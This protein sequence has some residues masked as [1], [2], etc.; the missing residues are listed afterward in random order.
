MSGEDWA[1]DTVGERID[2]LVRFGFNRADIEAFLNEHE[3]GQRERL[4]W[5]EERREAASALEDRI[6]AFS[7]HSVLGFEA[8]EPYKSRLSDPFTIEETFLE[9]ERELRSLAPWEPPLNREKDAWFGEGH[10]DM[11]S[12]LYE[13]LAALDVSSHAAVAPLHRLFDSPL[14]IDELLR[15]LELVEADERRQRQMIQSGADHLRGLGYA[16]GETVEQPLLEA[17]NQL[18]L[19]QG[20][21]A[22]KELVRLNA[23]QMIQPFDEALAAEFELR[24]SQLLDKENQQ[25]LDELSSEV[26]EVAQTLE[27][28]RQVFSDRI[29]EWRQQGIVF[30]HEGD[31][32]PSDL[33]EWEANHDTIAASV[34]RHLELVGRWERFARYWPSRVEGSR[35]L[36]GH[37]EMTDGLQDVVDELDALWKQLELDGLELLQSYEHAGLAV[38]AWQQ[39]VFDDPLNALERMTAERHRWDRRVEIME[40]LDGLD[41]SFIGDEEVGVRRHLLTAEE[42]EDDVLEEME[43]YVVKINRRNERHRVMLEEELASM[44]RSGSLE[45]ETLTHD[46]SLRELEQHVA[47]LMRSGGASIPKSGTS[48]GAKRI[49]A[50]LMRELTALKRSGWAVDAWMESVSE[51]PVRVARELSE[52]RPHVE[53]HEILR[54]RLSALPWERDIELAMEVELHIKQPDRLAH[55]SRNIPSFTTHLAS[56]PVEDETYRLHLWQPERTHPTLVPVPEQEERP[57]LQ[58]VTALDEAHEAMLESMELESQTHDEEEQIRENGEKATMPTP[59]EE[60][61][62]VA[63]PEEEEVEVDAPSATVAKTEN[64]VVGPVAEEIISSDIATQRAL[65]ALRELIALLGLNGLADEVTQQGMNALPEVRRGLAKHVNIAPRDVRVGRLLRLTLRLLPEGNKGDGERARMLT[66]LT[67]LVAPLKRW[68][69]RRLEARHSGARG[70]F[71]ADAVELGTAL[72]R[73]PGLGRHVPLEKDD[74]PLPSELAG[75]SDEI[76]KLAQSVNLPS[77]GGVKA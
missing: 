31:L 44:R 64:V 50:P 29:R 9:V 56:R 10:G 36:V 30:P 49:Q 3:G 54:R 52:A 4:T 45:R 73:I 6:A 62:E 21:H 18:E 26:N 41:T 68:M 66:E 25:A 67:Q 16:L 43:A 63:R 77:A 40:A 24:C 59:A 51:D 48:A 1:N 13:R 37:L 74:W 19:W 58:P 65:D 32:H 61:V 22:K 75:L 53:H 69:R 70:D 76:K 57:V 27:Q 7:Q 14:S 11:W 72:E 42:L 71:L 60:V 46:M 34:K 12:M 23:V 15:H 8:L 55:L 38:G 20:F 28:R 5:L 33:M 47:E 39:R 2:S 35:D 17:L